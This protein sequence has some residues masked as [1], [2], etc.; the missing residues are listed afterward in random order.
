MVEFLCNLEM[1]VW[2]ISW[3]PIPPLIAKEKE[4]VLLYP[5]RSQEAKS[6]MAPRSSLLFLTSL[7]AIAST[8]S[9]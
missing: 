3:N 5:P 6:I 9:S 2:Q 8:G 4:V 1:K 7:L